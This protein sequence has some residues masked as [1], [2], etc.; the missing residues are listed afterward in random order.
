MEI[1]P[2]V[3]SVALSVVAV[4]VAGLGFLVAVEAHRRSARGPGSSRGRGP[5]AAGPVPRR[6]HDTEAERDGP[7]GLDQG[8]L[9]PPLLVPPVPDPP[10]PRTFDP[11]TF[12]PRALDP[13]ALRD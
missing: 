7:D 2:A 9:V 8:M 3:I 5:Y 12:D 11:R 6:R 10:D 1:E 13:R 4:M